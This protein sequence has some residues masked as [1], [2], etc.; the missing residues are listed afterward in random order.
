[1]MDSFK[2]NLNP[3]T[4]IEKQWPTEEWKDKAY[5]YFPAGKIEQY[6]ENQNI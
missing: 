1:M 2:L 6:P 4:F 5:E 3:A